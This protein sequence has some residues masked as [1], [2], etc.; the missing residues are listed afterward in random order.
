[1]QKIELSG[2]KER[3]KV[4]LQKLLDEALKAQE[5]PKV[6][7]R[8]RAEADDPG[9]REGQKVAEEGKQELIRLLLFVAPR[10]PMA[11]A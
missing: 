3:E 5:E 10:P 9:A 7:K 8:S 1:M 4:N 6:P 11:L 2:S